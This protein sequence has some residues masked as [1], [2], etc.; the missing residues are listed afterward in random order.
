MGDSGEGLIDADAKIQERL[1]EL[2]RSR[3]QASKPAV[4]NPEQVRRIE[5]LKLARTGLSRQ[6]EAATHPIRKT[7][8]ADAIAEL[9]RQIAAILAAPI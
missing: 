2:Q 8:L 5:S 6:L 9:D 7:Q 1:E 3:E 4:A